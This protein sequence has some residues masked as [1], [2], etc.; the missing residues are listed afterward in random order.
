MLL[1]FLI[2]FLSELEITLGNHH[3]A[4]KLQPIENTFNFNQTFAVYSLSLL[5]V[6][7]DSFEKWFAFSNSI[8]F[9]TTLFNLPIERKMKR[10]FQVTIRKV[11]TSFVCC[12][13]VHWK[14][15]YCQRMTT[16][17]YDFV[18]CVVS[19]RR[20]DKDAKRAYKHTH[21]CTHTFK[22]IN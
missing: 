7:F 3:L 20:T 22:H 2:L 14:L 13:C 6:F 21:S 1:F 11:E 4:I 5:L 19:V 17:T 9:A 12:V 10:A 16:K 18:I 15:K 8:W